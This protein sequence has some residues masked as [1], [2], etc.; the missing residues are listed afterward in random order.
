MELAQGMMLGNCNVI[1][2]EIAARLSINIT[3]S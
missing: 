1:T 3:H 2:V